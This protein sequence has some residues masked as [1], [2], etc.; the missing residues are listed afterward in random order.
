MALELSNGSIEKLCNGM[1]VQRPI[2]QL[3]GFEAVQVKPDETNYR[4]VLS[5]GIHMNSYFFLCSQLNDLIIKKQVK[6]ATILRI[7]EYKFMD[8]ENSNDHS[9]RWI[10]LIQKVTI[11]IHRNVYGNP[12]P[13]INIEKKK[14]P[15][16]NLNVNKTPSRIFYCIE[17]LENNLM[18]VKD[19]ITLSNGSCPFVLK[20][21][22]VKKYAINTYSSCRVLNV[23]MMDS[24]GVVRVSA[25]NTLSDSLNEIFE[26]NKTYYLA[27]TILKHNQF[28]VELKLQ[29]HSVIIE[30]IDKIQP[31][32]QYIKTSNFNKLLENNPNT[33]CDLIGVCIE[34]GDIEAC[35]N[36]T[37]RTEI[38]KREIVLIDMSMATIT[39]KVWG[40][41]VNKFDEKFDNPPI[42]MVKQAVL[43]QFNGAKYFS[44]V[45]F[46]VLFIN[47]NLAEVHQLKEWYKQLIAMDDF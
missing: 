7:D 6:Y 19:L 30:S 10:I 12:Q 35:S 42:V 33:F 3:L 24:T 32:I 26:E 28:G 37:S 8:G 13:L 40:D 43:K 39:L 23:N 46:S 2:V 47:P 17:H 22:V 45:K 34:I 4:L 27:D 11:L 38:G 20:L 36:S 14:M 5:D 31:K 18:S 29:S 21:T 16:I 41:Q 9:P 15:L 44:M 1:P 25:F